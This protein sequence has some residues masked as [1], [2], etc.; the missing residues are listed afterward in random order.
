MGGGTSSGYR[1]EIRVREIIDEMLEDAMTDAPR[2]ACD[3]YSVPGR[4]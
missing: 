3:E 2:A 4:Q 1:K